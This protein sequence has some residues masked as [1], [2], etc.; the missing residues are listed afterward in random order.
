MSTPFRLVAFAALLSAVFAAAALAGDRIDWTPRTDGDSSSAHG[1]PGEGEHMMAAA[2][3]SK[4]GA[5]PGLAISQ[6]GLTL[7]LDRTRIARDRQEQFGFRILGRD[8][9]PVR[10]FDVEHTR[11]MHMIVVRRDATGFQHL[12][13][14]LGRDGT[15][16]VALRLP[17]AGSYRVFADFATNG[18]KHTLGADLEVDG[19]YSPRPLP[20]PATSATVDGYRVTLDSGAAPAGREHELRFSVTR[21]GRPVDVEPYLG[22]RGHLVALREGDLAFLHVH[23]DA[24]S[25]SFMTEF[26]SAGRYRLFLQFR[27]AGRIHT[28]AFTVLERPEADRRGQNAGPDA[29]RR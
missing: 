4:A 16:R 14:T 22:A 6:D 3:A 19:T 5:L 13:P 26:P 21:G 2:P 27:D 17:E 15:W 20:A 7:A 29:P 11:R 28:A 8:G 1:E 10:A 12:H 24:D 9:A 23:P 25:P 18:V